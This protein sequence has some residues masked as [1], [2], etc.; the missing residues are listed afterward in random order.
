MVI[1]SA[2]KDAVRLTPTFIAEK[3]IL[4][5]TFLE[6]CLPHSRYSINLLCGEYNT[7]NH[8]L[9]IKHLCTNTAVKILYILIYLIKIHIMNLY[10]IYM[11]ES[12][13]FIF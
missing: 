6:Q 9:C 8:G 3:I 2:G 11:L 1:L 4:G 12:R 5:S 7:N 13:N 10:D